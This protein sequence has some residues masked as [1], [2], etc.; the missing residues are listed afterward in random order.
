MRNSKCILFVL[1]I[2][3]IYSVNAQLNYP[4]TKKTPVIDTYHGIEVQDN[5]QWLENTENPEIENWLKEQ[6]DVSLNYL[7]NISDN[8]KSVKKIESLFWYQHNFENYNTPIEKDNI[9]R[10]KLMYP[11]KN[12]PISIYYSK[13]IDF[14]FEKI[15]GPSSISA[16]DKITFKSLKPSYDDRFLAYQYSRNGSDWKEIK[17]VGIKK[18]YFFKETLKNIFNPQINWYG[19][20][21]FYVKNKVSK[22]EFPEIMYHKLDTKQEEDKKIF[23]VENK[24]ERLSI[25]GT[26]NQSLFLIKKYDNFKKIFSYYYLEPKSE[27][28]EFKPLF[29]DIKYDMSIVRYKSDTIVALTKIKHKSFLI[30]FPIK[31]PKKWVIISPSYQNA[32]LTDYEFAGDKLVTAYQTEKE[33]IITISNF[34]GNVLGEITTPEG[35]SVNRLNF[36]SKTKEFFFTL[37]S[38]T[39]PP[40]YCSLDLDKYSFEYLGK[41]QVAFDASNYKFSR[42]KFKS[43][44]GKE[45]PIF[46]VYKDSIPKNGKTPFLLKTYGGYGLIAKPTFDPGILYFIEKGGA[47]AYV[48]IRGGGEFGYDWWQQGKNLNK[49]NGI[50][51]F[52]KAAEYLIENNFSSAKRIG[53]MGGSHGGLITAAAMIKE[54]TYF[55]AAVVDV[56]VLDVLRMETTE[57]GAEF[58]NMSEFGT[59]TKKDEFNNMLSYSPFHTIDSS[60]NYPSTLIITGSNDTRVVPSQSYKFAGKLQNGVNQKNPILL[61]TQEKTGHNGAIDYK[62]RRQEQIFIY[63]F[64]FNELTKN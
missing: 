59:V 62:K 47:F 49:K 64:L 23:N 54:P 38:Y 10:Y 63:S 31:Q 25:Y 5:Y 46:I 61:W 29:T 45:I 30:K 12:S 15:V 11:G 7:K 22:R 27:S 57:N 4:T 55:G 6:N 35:M 40:V 43:H 21:F 26:G 42:Q 58:I 51:D 60:I 36:N 18:R 2:L 16:K 48:H 56:G 14:D 37:S 53:I 33:S 41:T 24:N 3:S 17:I 20:G 34:K 19:Q 8:Y 32:V 50:A 44:D 28:K 39:V 13:G 9:V 1:L 52:T